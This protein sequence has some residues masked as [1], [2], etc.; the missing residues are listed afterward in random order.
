MDSW[1]SGNPKVATVSEDGVVTAVAPGVAIIYAKS[2]RVQGICT[3]TYSSSWQEDFEYE[4]LMGDG[5]NYIDL[6]LYNG[7]ATEYYVPKEAYID[8]VVYKTRLRGYVNVPVGNGMVTTVSKGIFY[9]NNTLEEITIEEGVETSYHIHLFFSNC[10]KLR[11]VVMAGCDVTR[12]NSLNSLFWNSKKL[13]TIDLSGCDFS[14][15][16]FP[17]RD[18]C[19]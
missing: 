6:I 15:L 16:S 19:R 9:E 10:S 4:L 7:S 1:R 17:A 8:G 11:N 12:A 2:G 18:V 3:I 14:R 13:E 5:C